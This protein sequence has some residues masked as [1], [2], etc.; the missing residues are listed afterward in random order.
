MTDD[1]KYSKLPLAPP[2]TDFGTRYI[3]GGPMFVRLN[4]LKY[5]PIYEI[6]LLSKTEENL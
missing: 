5:Y 4:F 1:G 6:I 2:R 3:Q